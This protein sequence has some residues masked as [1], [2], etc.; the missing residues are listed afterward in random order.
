MVF[1]ESLMVPSILAMVSIVY[2]L[3]FITHFLEM[4]LGIPSVQKTF[5]CTKRNLAQSAFHVIYSKLANHIY[6]LYHN[7]QIYCYVT[8]DTIKDKILY[9]NQLLTIFYHNVEE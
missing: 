8:Y 1:D 7:R 4:G 9:H 6:K 5:T 2:I 3:S